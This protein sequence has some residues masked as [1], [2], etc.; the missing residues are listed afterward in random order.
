[1]KFKTIGLLLSLLVGQVSA[2]VETA[3]DANAVI[4]AG[5]DTVAYHT[6]EKAVKGKATITAVH[7]GAIYRFSSTRN[8]DLFVGNPG[9]YAPAYGGYCAFGASFGK[10]FE[11]D[12]K[13]FEVVNG[14]LYVNKNLSVYKTWKEDIP[15]NIRQSDAQWPQIRSIAPDAL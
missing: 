5:Y 4:L 2:G 14:Q 7:E 15:G 3:T 8:R 10:K 12:G 6:Q 13:A 1:M 11:V 9:R